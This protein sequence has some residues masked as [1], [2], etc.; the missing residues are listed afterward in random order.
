MLSRQKL[1]TGF[2]KNSFDH[3]LNV[4]SMLLATRISC[5]HCLFRDGAHFQLELF[6]LINLDCIQVYLPRFVRLLCPDFLSLSSSWR[7]LKK[8]SCSQAFLL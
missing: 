1:S 4:A 5:T 3:Q 6:S 7:S 2:L 8:I